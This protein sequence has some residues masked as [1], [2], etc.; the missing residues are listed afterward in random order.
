MM[1]VLTVPRLRI[2]AAVGLGGLLALG[3]AYVL[4]NG[5]APGIRVRW[6][7]D[8]SAERQGELERKYL[9]ANGRAPMD[10][11]PRSLA[12][13]LID[14]SRW[15]IRALVQD[16][17]VA[18]T[19][20][21]DRNEFRVRPNTQPGERSTWL[22][23]WIP[24]LRYVGVLWA[25]VGA[26]LA[27]GLVGAAGLI[28][29]ERR[30]AALR[31]PRAA[32]DGDLF[33]RLPE[34]FTRL[35][36]I[37]SGTRPQF[38]TRIAA[39]VFVAAAIGLPVLDT[40]EALLLVASLFLVVF[41]AGRPERW[42]L[43]AAAAIVLAIVGVKAVLPRADI[44]EAHNVFM[45]LGDGGPLQRGLPP[46]IFAS[47]QAQFERLHPRTAEV[48]PFSWRAHAA[49]PKSLFVQSADSIWRTPKYSRQ[50]DA[51]DFTTLGEFRGAFANDITYNFWAGD[52]SRDSL[53]FYVMYELTP[54]SAGSRL[55]WQGQLFWEGEGGRFEEVV[56]A[57]PAS[58]EIVPADAGRRVYAA[59]FP[60]RDQARRFRLEPSTQLTA[61]TWLRIGLTVAGSFAVLWLMVRPRWGS[62]LRGLTMFALA[63]WL[64]FTYVDLSG[65][66]FLGRDYPPHGGGD[67]GLVH[68]GWGHSMALLARQGDV[69]EALKGSEA[70]Y[71]FTPGMRYVRMLEKLIFGDTNL[72]YALWLACVPLAMF[73]LLRHFVRVRWA[74]ILTAGF[75]LMP[76]GNLSYL[77]YVTNGRIGYGEGA[78]A[79]LFILGTALLLRTQPAWGG[80]ERNG[81]MTAMAGAA[82]ALS[83]FVR[84]NFILAAVWLAAMWSLAS[85]RRKDVAAIV[86][87]AIGLAFALWMPF[88]NWYYGGEFFLVSRAGA[89]LSIPLG[90]R[91][92]LAAARDAAQGQ[93]D[94]AAVTVTSAQVKGWLSAPAFVDLYSGLLAPVA[95]A[96]HVFRLIALALTCW[97]VLRW[98]VARFARGTDLAVIAVAALLAH[99]PM[100]FVHATFDRYA[101]LA[102]D[103]SILVLVLWVLRLLPSA[104]ARPAPVTVS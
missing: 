30:L 83:S 87:L 96:A 64:M 15:N 78:A 4:T 100:L 31:P 98:A 9:L 27:I 28:A 91:D 38:L 45:L 76:V 7:D 56:H 54:A 41:S 2:C 94:T 53:P 74:W 90:P 6:R 33:D 84:P 26:L 79:G 77:Q 3:L 85:L 71:W 10:D 12:Y 24:L 101:M 63:W 97:V 36:V 58:R 23:R 43:A 80:L 8:L 48:P 44:A 37:P 20:D 46:E 13:D 62:Y 99:V 1:P 73:Y 52:L 19:N 16:P 104:A 57:E 51:I 93:F 72:L 29:E 86:P 5:P 39:G 21:L 95:R 81:S 49:E 32:D 61:S 18:D 70:V 92:Y 17:D 47:W 89:T 88:H 22:A 14:T 102:W 50:V 75:C 59:F 103:L 67:D 69:V 42:R 82:L 60:A 35:S 25:V 34:M 66:H 65:R 55:A 40:W 11:A 68:D